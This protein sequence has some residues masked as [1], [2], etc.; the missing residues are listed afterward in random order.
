M[1][2]S[3]ENSKTNSFF[4]PKGGQFKI[5]GTFPQKFFGEMPSFTKTKLV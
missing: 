5:N 2:L 4:G 3:F 1:P